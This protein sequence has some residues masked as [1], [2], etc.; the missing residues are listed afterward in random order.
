MHACACHAPC[1]AAACHQRHRPRSCRHPGA[2]DDRVFAVSDCF[3]PQA[4]FGTCEA[5]AWPAALL[6]LHAFLVA[7]MGNP[8]KPTASP[9]PACCPADAE[10]VSVAEEHLALM[11]EHLSFEEAAT[12]PLVALTAWQVGGPL[13]GGQQGAA[14]QPAL[15]PA[16]MLALPTSSGGTSSLACHHCCRPTH[17][18]PNPAGAGQPGAAA[19]RPHPGATRQRRG[20]QPGGAAGQAPGLARHHDLQPEEQQLLQA[21]LGPGCCGLACA[22]W[23]GGLSHLQGAGSGWAAADVGPASLAPATCP[24]FTRCRQLGA[25]QVHDYCDAALLAKL[26]GPG[27]RQFD[28]IFE[29]VGGEDRKR[30]AMLGWPVAGRCA[31]YPGVWLNN[32]Q[33][34]GSMPCRRHHAGL[35]PTSEARRHA[36]ACVDKCRKVSCRCGAASQSHVPA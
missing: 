9:A 35:P 10:L 3:F 5:Q 14:W 4:E 6:S 8:W 33:R 26:Y 12:I 22:L 36:S 24:L 25:D 19:R 17:M 13:A 23:C 29:A 11:P 30:A 28:A 21:G 31:A 18:P 2:Q 16:A 34:D 15:A 32:G 7:C 27:G 20:G 1:H